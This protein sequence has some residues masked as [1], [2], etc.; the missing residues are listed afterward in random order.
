MAPGQEV[1]PKGDWSTTR[2]SVEDGTGDCRWEWILESS[3][4][5]PREQLSS[6]PSGEAFRPYLLRLA[7][8]E[9]GSWRGKFGNA[10]AAESEIDMKWSKHLY[11]A[12]VRVVQLFYSLSHAW[13]TSLASLLSCWNAWF[14]STDIRVD[15]SLLNPTLETVMPVI[16]E[17]YRLWELLTSTTIAIG[18]LLS[19]LSSIQC[20]SMILGSSSFIFIFLAPKLEVAFCNELHR[21][22]P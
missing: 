8:Q 15:V 11:A 1:L 5:I 3:I 6:S 12:T 2:V 7:C 14:Q 16:W 4:L 20:Y 13:K 19:L 21:K 10:M 22:E 17:H 18:A 9:Y